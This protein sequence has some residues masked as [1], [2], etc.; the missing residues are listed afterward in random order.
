MR[1]F[2][3]ANFLLRLITFGAIGMVVFWSSSRI[4]AFPSPALPIS[5]TYAVIGLLGTAVIA[6]LKSQNQRIQALEKQLQDRDGR[7]E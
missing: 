5:G 7:A 2:S 1:Q 4:T 6:S 3:G